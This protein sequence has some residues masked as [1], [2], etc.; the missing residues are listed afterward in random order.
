MFFTVT[1][2]E[3]PGITAKLVWA[4]VVKSV[5]KNAKTSLKP[6]WYSPYSLDAKR[7]SKLKL[8][9]KGVKSNWINP[10][11]VIA[12]TCPFEILIACKSASVEVE[13]WLL[14]LMPV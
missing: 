12:A 9:D 14:S 4:L 2:V 7:K 6:H 10:T 11:S 13:I 1:G 8:F 5:N 3:V